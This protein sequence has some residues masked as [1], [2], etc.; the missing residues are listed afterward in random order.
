[1]KPTIFKIATRNSMI[2]LT[3][4]LSLMMGCEEFVAIDPP[5]TQITEPTVFT[6][7]A[8]AQA[9]V[10]GVYSKMMESEDLFTSGRNS[11]TTLAGLSSGELVNY[12]NNS[13]KVLYANNQLNATA[14]ISLWSDMYKIIYFA[15]AA[16]EGLQK[17]NEISVNLKN[18]LLGEMFFVRAYCHFYLVNLFGEIP[19]VTTTDYRKNNQLH[20]SPVSEGYDQIVN[21]LKQAQGQLSADYSY[22]DGERTRPNKWAATAMLARVYLY[23]E[24]WANAEM[25]ATAVIANLDFALESDLNNVFLANSKE[26]IWQLKPVFP[27]YN[28]FDGT[29]FILESEPNVVALSEQVIN[30]FELNDG[31][32]NAW[33]GTLIA[34]GN[35]YYYADK[36]KIRVGFEVKEYLMILRL[37][38][39]YLIRAEARAHQNKLPEA[40]EDIN[41]I[42]SRAGVTPSSASSQQQVLSETE[43]ERRIELFCEW[44]HRW[45]DLK[46][47]KRIDAVRSPLNPL[48]E[49]TD[50][51]YPIP[52]SEIG[53]N[54]NLGPQNP[55]Y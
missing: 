36:Y 5:T 14:T 37:A 55:G 18:Q 19:I 4:L 30:D 41:L 42:R 54:P 25:Q 47:T 1:M 43:N 8:T 35:N 7:D 39:Q 3:F 23:R 24:D 45:L 13:T 31:R 28:T 29:A 38:E 52:E 11:I 6:S 27:G 10:M 33:V 22:S 26:A 9:A 32:G 16:I 44:G 12:D 48:W 17:S 40:S 49:T 50:A 21:D 2:S 53:N 34:G 51:L 15:N 46:R 20:R